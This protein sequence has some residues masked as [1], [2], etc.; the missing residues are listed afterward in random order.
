MAETEKI[1]T[2]AGDGGSGKVSEPLLAKMKEEIEAIVSDAKRDLWATRL[3]AED[4]RLARWA[5]QSADGLKH[6]VDLGDVPEPFEGASDIRVRLADM[7]TNEEVM[8]C[9]VSALRAQVIFKGVESNDAAQAGNCSIVLRWVLRNQLGIAWIEELAKLANYVSGDSPGLGFMKIWWRKEKALRMEKL[10]ADELMRMYVERVVEQLASASAGPTADGSAVAEPEGAET[11]LEQARAAA[12][13]FQAALQDPA[14]GEEQLTGLMLEFFPGIQEARAG[15]VIR[16]LRMTGKAEFPV[17]YVKHNG[18]CVQSKRLM[19][20]WF[21]PSNMGNFQDVRMWFENEWLSEPQLRERETSMEY[22]PDWV[23]EVLKHEAV[24]AFPDFVKDKMGKIVARNADYYRGLYNVVTCYFAAVNEDGAP[25]RYFVT[26]HQE[27]GFPAHERTLVDYEHG[28]YPGHV[29]R[30]EMTSDRATDSR[31]IPEVAGPHQGITKLLADSFGDHAQIAGVPP[32][33]TH[34]RQREGALRIKPLM[35]LQAKRDGDYKWLQPPAYPVT[36]KNMLTEL[37]RQTDEYFGRTNPE[38]GADVVSLHKEFRVMWWLANVR[39]ILSQIWALCQQY[40]PN[41]VLQRITNA[42][43]EPVARTV[44]DIQ[45]QYDLELVFDARDMDPA[46]LADIAK[47]VK[48][49][50]IAMDRDKTIN[51]SP[52]VASLLWRLAPD[53]AEMALRPVDVALQSEIEAEKRAY[54]EIRGGSEPELPDDGS[55]NYQVRKQWYDDQVKANP[56]MFADMAEDKTAILASRLQR[57]GVLE[58]QYG[59]NVDI[60]RQGGKTALPAEEGA[61]GRSPIQEGAGR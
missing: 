30:R 13:S 37:R 21:I 7:L 49:L 25:G 22:D 26:L 32:I 57:M 41:E 1:D 47:T 36:L 15:K 14:L 43:G 5:G 28:K 10:T 50:L 40:M 16:E 52:I 3:D 53:M 23:K 2:V 51:T 54:L 39:E 55:I 19:E 46:F 59:E 56:A 12:E 58:E 4:T 18:P 61:T 24:A 29:V 8:L 34:G 44:E 27:V 38:V 33:V 42:Q 60:G 17:P 35:E 31:G 48:D 45:G 20:N 9:V 6:E 11:L